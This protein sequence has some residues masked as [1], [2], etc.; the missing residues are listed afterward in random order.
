MLHITCKVATKLLKYL[1][2]CWIPICLVVLDSKAI[3]AKTLSHT[4]KDANSM[5]FSYY[6]FIP[7]KSR[8]KRK[9]KNVHFRSSASASLTRLRDQ[10]RQDEWF[11]QCLRRCWRDPLKGHIHS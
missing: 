3:G 10:L 1:D 5:S 7:V 2:C 9:G 6:D 4:M 11:S 8:K